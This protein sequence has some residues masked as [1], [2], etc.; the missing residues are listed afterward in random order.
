VRLPDVSRYHAAMESLRDQELA[1]LRKTPP[2]E[3]ARQALDLMQTGI[4]LKLAA[5]RSRHPHATVEEIEGMMDAWLRG[6]DR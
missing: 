5:L 2:G 1:E 6:Q 4:D 3:K